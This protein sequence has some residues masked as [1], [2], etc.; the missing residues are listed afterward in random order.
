MNDKDFRAITPSTETALQAPHVPI[1]ESE[2][3]GQ[4][5]WSN[6][7]LSV[8]RWLRRKL[9]TEVGVQM[10]SSTTAS[11][12][13]DA[14]RYGIIKRVGYGPDR[15]KTAWHVKC[16]QCP[17]QFQ[18]T[19]NPRT[20]PE[21][22]V[23]NLRNRK[24]SVGLGDRPLCPACA[25]PRVSHAPAKK[26]DHH[27]T[28]THV[29]LAPQTT[30][31]TALS[32]A[33]EV[34]VPPKAP[35][36]PQEKGQLGM[37][38]RNQNKTYTREDFVAWGKKGGRTN[39]ATPSPYPPR[40]L[41]HEE[42]SL[43]MRAAMLKSHARRKAAKEALTMQTISQTHQTPIIQE[44]PMTNANGK[45]VPTPSP[46]ISH[47]VFNLLDDVFLA[48]KRLYKS[49]YS[50]AKVATDCGTSEDVVAY[51]RRETFGE[52]SEDPRFSTMR[53]DVEMAR[54]ELADFVKAMDEKF[55][56][57]GNRLEQIA[58]ATKAR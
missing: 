14:A 49:G 32:K 10:V 42:R 4:A 31:F 40:R 47:A 11:I 18:A 37:A 55:R 8:P 29:P 44:I 54:L 52:L 46:K 25:H 21:L 23:K 12:E 45:S 13:I 35:M 33:V 22:M 19:W 48:D 7:L 43:I 56:G 26:P 27:T 17:R 57:F 6:I 28:E 38:A 30:L 15:H 3:M 34:K 2:W 41:T 36:T 53:D 20:S 39:Y 50:D 58:S 51:L 5:E 24:W 16:S 1:K 9:K